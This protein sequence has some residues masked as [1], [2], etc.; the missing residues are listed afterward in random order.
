MT[1]KTPA[2]AKARTDNPIVIE[3][4]KPVSSYVVGQLKQD[5]PSCFNGIV[6]VRRYRIT[7]EPIEEPTEII[8]QRLQQLWDACDNHHH[9]GP[10]HAAAKAIGWDLQGTYGSKKKS[11]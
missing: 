9:A 2:G 5:S 6:E 10:L 4:F 11:G 8:G 3:T 1:K 7:I